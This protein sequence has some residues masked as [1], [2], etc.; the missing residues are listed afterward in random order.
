VHGGRIW[1][2]SEGNGAGAAMRFTLPSMTLEEA[3]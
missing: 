3:A 2:E 1:I